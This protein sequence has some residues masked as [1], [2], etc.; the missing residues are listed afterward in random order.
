MPRKKAAEGAN[1]RTSK[2][3]PGAH[4]GVHAGL[5]RRTVN[6]QS[7][8]PERCYL[9]AQPGN[10]TL[11]TRVCQPAVLSFWPFNV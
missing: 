1:D 2:Q 7:M 5:G 4:T 11:A 8:C 9:V 6:P 3:K 10:C